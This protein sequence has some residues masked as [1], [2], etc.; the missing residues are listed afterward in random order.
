M[1]TYTGVADGNGDFTVSFLTEYTGGEKIT[2]TAEKDNATK[3]IELY[4]PSNHID[5]GAAIKFSGSLVD[6][7]LNI[8]EVTI[9]GTG[10]IKANALSASASGEMG[11]SSTKLTITGFTSIE[12]TAF[13]A[14]KATNGIILNPP[15]LTIGNSAFSGTAAR[16]IDL[17][18]TITSMQ[19]A[20]FA[21]AT[22]ALEII[23]RAIIPPSIS[24]GTFTGVKTDC[25]FKVPATSVAAYQ[26]APNWSAF[27]AR[28]QAI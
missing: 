3:T 21:N 11:R 10:A 27:A 25:V 8:G 24:A 9:E 16:L 15:L 7:P 2:V 22:A 19:N 13:L 20:A 12:D 17:P 6:F 1:A 28:I 5:V 18:S 23:C 4:A 14:W 26:A